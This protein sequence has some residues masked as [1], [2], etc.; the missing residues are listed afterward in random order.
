MIKAIGWDSSIFNGRDIGKIFLNLL[1]STSAAYLLMNL[2]TGPLAKFFVAAISGA[3]LYLI[4]FSIFFR[5]D[6][7]FLLS[8]IVNR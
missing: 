8:F 1:I 5:R 6:F 7:K 2:F 4:F 3:I